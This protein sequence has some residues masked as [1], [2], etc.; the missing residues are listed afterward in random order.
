MRQHIGRRLAAAR[1]ALNLSAE[2][3]AHTLG[4]SKKAYQAWEAGQNTLPPLV[5]YRLFA[6]EGIPMEW[7]YAGDLRRAEYARAQ[8]ITEAAAAVGAV[9]GGAVPQFETDAIPAPA[10]P[11]PRRLR[12]FHEGQ[13]TLK[14]Q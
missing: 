3:M 7:I 14:A 9:I 10:A 5:A 1:L 6:L 8:A 4:V 11:P 2:A 12:V 13:K